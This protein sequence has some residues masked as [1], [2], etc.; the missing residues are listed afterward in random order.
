MSYPPEDHRP[1]QSNEGPEAPYTIEQ[2]LTDYQQNEDPCPE[3]Q[4]PKINPFDPDDWPELGTL[5]PLPGLEPVH[6]SEMIQAHIRLIKN[7]ADV[8]DQCGSQPFR[9]IG[10]YARINSCTEH[11]RHNANYLFR[12]ET[13]AP[14]LTQQVANQ[15]RD[16][17]A[18]LD[19]LS[20]HLQRYSIELIQNMENQIE[21]YSHAVAI[22]AA[23]ATITELAQRR[24]A[25]P[26]DEQRRAIHNA[27]FHVYQYACKSNDCLQAENHCPLEEVADPPTR[28]AWE[29]CQLAYREQ[30]VVYNAS[31]SRT[32]ISSSIAELHSHISAEQRHTEPYNVNVGILT[33][34]SKIF[35]VLPCPIRRSSIPYIVYIHRDTRYIQAVSDPFPPQIDSQLAIK[36]LAAAS[37]ITRRDSDYNAPHTR[38]ADLVIRTAIQQAVAG[39]ASVSPEDVKNAAV[40]IT[41]TGVNPVV[42]N[43][44]IRGSLPEAPQV[45]QRLADLALLSPD[46]VQ[47]KLAHRV[48]KDARRAG[49]S[50][51]RL[52]D[53]AWAMGW[54]RQ[55]DLGV[56]TVTAEEPQSDAAYRISLEAG[57]PETAARRIQKLVGDPKPSRS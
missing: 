53:L 27:L 37:A 38:H 24:A 5:R 7:A 42:A 50:D 32:S 28:D 12:D 16:S 10:A 39:L 31:I 11:L 52:A 56:P 43:R 6:R 3:D 26:D 14:E 15:L 47:R 20:V 30:V 2:L 34:Q 33:T 8:F 9:L 41:A 57:F 23:H 17:R 18:T 40:A 19:S 35:G 21:A 29:A 55:Q 51:I 4:Q 13:L 48:I 45:A 1:N 46:R 22:R 44:A 54:T 25:T 36:Q 49:L